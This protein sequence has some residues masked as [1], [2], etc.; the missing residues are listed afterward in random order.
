M[1]TF[2]VLRQAA[3]DTEWYS[4]TWNRFNTNP[5]GM[6][7]TTYDPVLAAI[8]PVV[9]QSMPAIIHADWTN[10]L[11]RAVALSDELGLQ[12]ILAGGMEAFNVADILREKDIPVLVSVNYDTRKPSRVSGVP[13]ET[14][15]TM[16]KSWRTSS[17]IRPFWRRPVCASRSNPVSQISRQTPSPTY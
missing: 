7:R 1:G 13:A 2:A 12:P 4:N 10:E 14:R 5:R 9:E 17:R 16:P 8:I 11:K 3:A 15:T 6:R